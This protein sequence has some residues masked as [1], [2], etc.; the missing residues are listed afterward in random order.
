MTLGEWLDRWLEEYKEGTIRPSTMQSYRQY[1][2]CYIKPQLGRKQ[3]SLITS[4]DIQR[5][6]RRLKKRGPYP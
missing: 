5:M 3:V 4:Q 1:I 2:D 6:Y